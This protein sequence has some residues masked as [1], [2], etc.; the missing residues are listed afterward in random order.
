MESSR[1]EFRIL[2]P[3]EVSNGDG[4][5]RI[6]GPRQRAL[7]AILLLSAN[8]VVSR[9]R[10]AEELFAGEEL[11]SAERALRVQISRLRAS[12]GSADGEPLIIN[13]PPGYLLRVGPDELD[14]LSF[15]QLLA[16]G[17]Q[18]LEDGDPRRA[19]R[20][21]REA[22][23]LWRGRPFADLEFE[24]FARVEVERLEQLRLGATEQR[25]EA[26]LGLGQHAVL[27]PELA[28]LVAVHPLRE[29]LRCQLMLALYRSGRQAE[30]LDSYRAGRKLSVDQLGLEPGRELKQLE[31]AILRHD[32][33]LDL[34]T[35][36][37]DIESVAATPDSKLHSNSQRGLRQAWIGIAATT[38][39]VGGV[40]LTLA[41]VRGSHSTA[42]RLPL[43]ESR[44]V[45]VSARNDK[46]VAS[47]RVQAAA[48]QLTRGFG[49][50]WVTEGDANSLER[51]DPETRTVSQTIGVGD[52]PFGIAVEAGD[53]W[54]AN[55]LD[56]TVS[57]IDASTNTLVQVVQVGTQPAAV[58]AAGGSIWV[59]NRGD[60]TVSR[61]NPITGR[62]V[63]VVRVGRGPSC[64]AA[65]ARTVWVCDQDDGAVTR[66]DMRDSNVV[67]T[68]HTGEAPSA[69]VAT[70]KN[71]WLL[72]SL[73]ATISRLDPTSDTIAETH[74]V[75]G[76][77]SA[78]AL[79][80]SSIWVSNDSTGRIE[81][82]DPD[83]GTI[84]HST[85]IGDRAGA[86]VA[87]PAG[88]W[89][90][91]SPG[92]ETHRGGTLRLIETTFGNASSI[93]PAVP[94][95]APPLALQALS[96]DGLVTL[97]H[98]PGPDGARLVPDLALSLPTPTDSG[99][100]YTFRL[101]PGIRFSNGAAVRPTDVRHSI[102][103]LFDRQVQSPG[104][105]FFTGI[106]GARECLQ[107]PTMCDLSRGIVTNDRVD[108]VSFHLAAP[109]PD[110]IFKLTLPYAYVLPAAIPDRLSN[111]PLPATGPYMVRSA[112]STTGVQLVRNPLFREWSHAAQPS[113][114][115]NR[116]EWLAPTR[117]MGA[118]LVLQGRADLMAAIGSI[119]GQQQTLR[120]RFPS[121]LRVNWLPGTE[122]F[123]LNT[124]AKPFNDLRVRR[125]LNYAINRNRIADLWGGPGAA[126]PTCQILPPQLPGFVRYCPFTRNPN[127]TGS[128][129]AP[130]L[131]RARALV[132]SSGTQGMHV[133]VWATEG[134]RSE[135]KEARYLAATLRRLGYRANIAIL[136]SQSLFAYANNSTNQAQVITGGWSADYPT[137]SDFLGKL[138]CRF[139]TPGDPAQTT[140][141]SELCDP[142]L[143]RQVAHADSLQTSDP[144]AAAAAWA[145]LDRTLTDRAVSGPDRHI[146]RDGRPLTPRRELPVPPPLGP[147]RRPALGPLTRTTRNRTHSSKRP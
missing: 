118:T 11:Q 22:E 47:V 117:T 82:I 62:V 143:D 75:G 16:T 55:T 104:T 139:F 133:T 142:T 18:A 108:T 147:D 53:V 84:I 52:D 130:N 121:L 4:P 140:D 58:L 94:T 37:T 116:I 103:R 137:A 96:N 110:F 125:A 81:R 74:P 95:Y 146:Q 34:A 72:D 129:Q 87:S 25:V 86:I 13:R 138:S 67:D 70:G 5:L 76:R 57:R 32:H 134:P 71:V 99:T 21:L 126:Q 29:R 112:S 9:D 105:D 100:T 1:L 109:D 61:I 49:S 101:R 66:I 107:Q 51:I 144:A 20:E 17:R 2:G 114:Y 44:L 64:L 135:A 10:L 40:A 35:P 6:G 119:G 59:A 41:V 69:I 136:P 50:L 63:R 12:L 23:S 97:D 19:A 31:Q 15:E 123:F 68:I 85:Q 127:T 128:W 111:S 46:P 120:T 90:A 89:V 48:T 38:I 42:T 77:P 124:R 98:V 14:L 145:R 3:L 92:G 27:V 122:F 28:A 78:V 113:G 39:A 73:D 88:L 131:Q 102:E 115:P 132:A 141:A 24:P 7:L 45:L 30:A 36:S 56:G 8:R 80:Q 79:A 43:R 65:T 60:G 93:D 33:A 26:E 106:L 83:H 91:T 54:V